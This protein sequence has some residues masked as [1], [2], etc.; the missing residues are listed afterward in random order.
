MAG[1]APD[2]G[3]YVPV[4]LPA[5]EVDAAP[6]NAPIDEFAA[7]VLR[8]FFAGSTLE[9]QLNDICTE[10]FNF[11]APLRGVQNPPDALSV[12]ELFHGPTA[13]FKDFGARFLATTMSRIIRNEGGSDD[14][15]ATIV[16]A[17]SGDTGGAVAAR[18][19]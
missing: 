8:P 11:P 5:A 6:V 7:F 4:E 12:L 16:V 19:P 10:A 18:V 14:K 3:L 2:G 1:T 9:G 13:A 15:P 17:T